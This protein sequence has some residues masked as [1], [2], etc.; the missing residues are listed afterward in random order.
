MYNIPPTGREFSILWVSQFCWLLQKSQIFTLRLCDWQLLNF[1][2][3]W[4]F[5]DFIEFARFRMELYFETKR[6]GL[7]SPKSI[8]NKMPLFS[9]ALYSRVNRFFFISNWN[10]KL[11]QIKIFALQFRC[12][13]EKWIEILLCSVFMVSA[14]KR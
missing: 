13:M 10:S 12:F 3:V 1:E 2:N 6:A 5:M 4:H 7:F 11:I 14:E 9:K 8:T